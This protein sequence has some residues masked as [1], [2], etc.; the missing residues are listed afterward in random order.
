MTTLAY[1]GAFLALAAL[2][3]LA[4]ASGAHWL[5]RVPVLAATPLLALAVWWQLSQQDGWPATAGPAKGSAF[6]ASVV[7][8]PTPSD[9]GAIYIWVQPPGTSTPRAYRMPYS[10]QLERQVNKAARE[11]KAGKPVGIRPHRPG[12]HGHGGASPRPLSLQFYRLPPA[13]SGTKHR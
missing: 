10:T 2:A 4:A 5:L 1:A 12:G 3:G 7:Q 8:S 9:H 11:Q 6:V 13:G